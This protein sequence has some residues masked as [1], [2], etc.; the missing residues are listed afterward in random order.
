MTRPSIGFGNPMQPTRGVNNARAT[1]RRRGFN[2]I[3]RA[4]DIG[5]IH[6]PIITQPQV[7][8]CRDM[9]TPIAIAQ[10]GFKFLT[11]ADIAL[12]AIKRNADQP[13]GIAAGTEQSPDKVPARNQ[14]VHQVGADKT[15][16]ARDEA[17]HVSSTK[18]RL[19]LESRTKDQVF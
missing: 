13:A 19:K 9:E 17:I 11:I 5:R 12:H 3:V 10:G 15:G 1:R 16:S 4:F 6:W 14:F 18:K 8:T 7:I 2:Y